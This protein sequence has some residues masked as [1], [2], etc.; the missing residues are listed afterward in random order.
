MDK[1]PTRW[2]LHKE[3]LDRAVANMGWIQLYK[4][5]E[6]HIL[7][8]RTSDHKPLMVSFTTVEREF[9]QVQRT[10][11]FE[12]KWLMDEES[13]DIITGAWNGCSDEGAS[14]QMVQQK[15]AHCK[16]A[17]RRWNGQ[18]YGCAEKAIKEKTKQLEILQRNERVEDTLQLSNCSKRLSSF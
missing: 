8:A 1:L 12:A 11:K 6:V 13:C 18:K 17:L 7:A 3:R 14:L 9:R 4:Q 2:E 16:S 10:S 5:V 15:L